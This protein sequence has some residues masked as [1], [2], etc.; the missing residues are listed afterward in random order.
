MRPFV[1]WN[2]ITLTQGRP[3]GT[4]D[5]C[6]P[7]DDVAL[8]PARTD[9]IE[10]MLAL[11]EDEVRAGRM[12]PRSPN[13]VR[14]TIDDWIVAAAGHEI[15]GCV[16]LVL[17]NDELCEVRSLA[18]AP[19][20]R[21]IGLGAALVEAALALARRRGMRRVLTLTR[22]VDFFR[23]LGFRVDRVARYPDKVWRDCRPCPLRHRCDEVALI[24]HLQPHPSRASQKG[25]RA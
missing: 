4:L 10:Q 15:V 7:L 11:F 14:A 16:S 23:R 9:E 8:R 5:G 20:C 12:L 22:A 19:A 25:D 6:I 2:E 24:Y 1:G 13:E 3:A 18:V 17:F 21:G